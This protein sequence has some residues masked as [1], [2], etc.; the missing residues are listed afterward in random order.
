MR[1]CEVGPFLALKLRAFLHRD[2][3][4]DVFDIL[5]TLLHYD[6]GTAAAFAAFAEEVRAQ[7]AACPDALHCLQRH[8]DSETSLGPT[9]AAQFFPGPVTPNES[10]DLRFQRLQIQQEM[11]NAARLL[12][13]GINF[14]RTCISQ[15]RRPFP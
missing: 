5:Y 15:N 8:F 1:V 12:K 9:R 3:A 6:G 7:N 14:N 13:A 10:P 2:Q 4:K 11:V